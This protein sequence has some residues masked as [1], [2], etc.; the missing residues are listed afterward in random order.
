MNPVETVVSAR[1]RT[2]MKTEMRLPGNGAARF[3]RAPAKA[4]HPAVL[5]LH[6]NSNKLGGLPF[7]E[8]RYRLHH[9][10]NS[11]SAWRLHL[12]CHGHGARGYLGPGHAFRE[13]AC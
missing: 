12:L 4:A 13:K 9:R 11:D 6:P 10:T 8:F 3:D 7:E 5:L 1:K 2:S